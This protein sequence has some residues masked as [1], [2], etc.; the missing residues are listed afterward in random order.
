M[1]LFAA[2]NILYADEIKSGSQRVT[3]NI[4]ASLLEA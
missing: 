2:A 3:G 4:P 1:E